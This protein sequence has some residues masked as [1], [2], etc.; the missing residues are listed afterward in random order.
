[1]TPHD[2]S[3]VKEVNHYGLGWLARFGHSLKSYI[4][5]DTAER[6]WAEVTWMEAGAELRARHGQ[7][8]RPLP[9]AGSSHFR[10]WSKKRRALD[11]DPIELNRIVV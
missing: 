2:Q 9:W 6:E 8:R 10:L 4:L 7:G 1:M 11:H 5:D 3:L